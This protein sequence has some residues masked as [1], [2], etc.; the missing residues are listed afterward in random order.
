M[1]QSSRATFGMGKEKGPEW[2]EIT[3][4]QELEKAGGNFQVKCGH[5]ELVF[6]GGATRIRGHFLG[7]VACGVKKCT[8]CPQALKKQLQDIDK[9]KRE[10][11]TQ[12][13]KVQNLDE[14]A[15]AL[16]QGPTKK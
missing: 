13:R 3:I 14:A 16:P 9:A 8:K 15:A 12:K 10:H 5:C 11:E 6:W 4:L 2:T 1:L 7:Q